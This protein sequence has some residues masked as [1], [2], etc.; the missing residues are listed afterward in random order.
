MQKKSN[1][2]PAKKNSAKKNSARRRSPKPKVRLDKYKVMMMSAV[3]CTICVLLLVATALFSGRNNSVKEK[4]SPEISMA[5]PVRKKTAE[6]KAAPRHDEEIISGEKPAVSENKPTQ[7]DRQPE[8]S[9]QSAADSK[10][11]SEAGKKVSPVPE[12]EPVESK[13]KTPEKV[14][15]PPVKPVVPQKPKEEP[16]NAGFAFPEAVNGAALCIVFDDGGQNIGQ[17]EKCLSL[18][19]PLTVAVMPRLAH[20]AEAARL[21]RMSGNELI[22]HQPMQA[23][24]LNVNP[25][26]GAITP[27]MSGAEIEA[28]LAQN[29][30][31]LGAIAGMNNHEGS[32]ITED[33]VKM[34]F[35]LNMTAQKGIYFLDSRT[36][37]AT[38]VPAVALSMGIGYYER[39]IFLDNEKTRDNIIS[40][41]RK[42]LKIANKKG[43]VIMIGHVWSAEIL[44]AVL[45]DVYPELLLKGYKF[46]KVSAAKMK[47]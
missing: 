44:P 7:K 46:S 31:E 18:P 41:L 8:K 25:G 37:S 32:L 15:Q 14:V 42:G 36:T 34:S 20:S 19:F 38:K 2:S 29:F 6:K 9:T 33:E 28:T 5:S 45:E 24:N 4:T 27:E 11:D 23:I 1:K 3:V 12:K 10:K 13:R 35:I 39:D 22:L 40:E 21:V 17:L 43:S 16:K 26:A 47:G 30:A